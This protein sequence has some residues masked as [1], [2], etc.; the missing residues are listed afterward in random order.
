MNQEIR[1]VRPKMPDFRHF[2]CISPAH[3][4]DDRYKHPP[5][6]EFLARTALSYIMRCRVRPF[7]GTVLFVLYSLKEWTL[8]M[9]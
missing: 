6:G 4:I 3:T 5:E 2:S 1:A 8:E 9:G 7:Y